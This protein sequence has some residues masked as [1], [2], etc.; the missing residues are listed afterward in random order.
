MVSGAA[1]MESRA[2]SETLV[3]AGVYRQTMRLL[4]QR[5]Y[6]PVI[7]KGYTQ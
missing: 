1:Q 3:S 5:V 6:L 4:N 2:T 7:L